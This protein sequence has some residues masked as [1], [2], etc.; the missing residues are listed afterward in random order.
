MQNRRLGVYVLLIA[1]LLI[2]L[3]SGRRFFFNIAYLFGALLIVSLIWS[4]TSVNWVRIMRQTRARRAQVGKTL[5]ETFTVRNTSIFPKIFL[6]VRDHSDVPGHNPSAVVPTLLPRRM[7]RWTA[8]TTC[9]VRGEF[10]LGPLTLISGDPFGFFQVTRH[11]AATSKV[12]IYPAT[13]PIHDFAAPTGLLTGGDAQRQ[14]AH[15]VTTNASGI[16]EYVPGDSF[17]RIHWKSSA[18]KDRLLVKEF[19]LDP[20]ADV[21]MFLDLSASALFERPFSA[22]GWPIGEFFIPP[23][24]E[25]YGVIIAASLAQYFLLDE[26][27]L[28]FVTYNPHRIVYQ[29]DRGNRQ[30]TRIL[31]ALAVARSETT[32]TLD[33]LLALEGHHMS[34]GTTVIIITADPSDEWIRE[35]NSL[36]RRGL[37]TIAVVMDPHSFGATHTRSM[38]RTRALLEVSGILSY[39]VQRGDDLTEDLSIR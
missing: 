15:F 23:S 27:S 35:A 4:W 6:E 37:R 36:V 24:T 1:C 29:P 31:E 25:E 8:Q 16:R 5:D 11:I 14:R 38:E 9:M 28:G 7:Y 2:G 19:E 26:R 18:R 13:V 17:N 12:L 32:M 10:T 20:M 22:E 21:W 34:R 39:G 33:Q 30:L 3:A